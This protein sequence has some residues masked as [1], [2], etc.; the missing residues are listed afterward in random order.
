MHEIY[1]KSYQTLAD[2]QAKLL[3]LHPSLWCCCYSFLFIIA[4][5]IFKF[6]GS[7]GADKNHLRSFWKSLVEGKLEL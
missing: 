1:W 3:T 4:E 7:M 5:T 6:I 2:G